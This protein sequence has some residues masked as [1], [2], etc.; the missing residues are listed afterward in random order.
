MFHIISIFR[1]VILILRTT[2]VEI[3]KQCFS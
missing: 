3:R 2:R 1:S